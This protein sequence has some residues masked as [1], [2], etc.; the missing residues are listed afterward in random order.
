MQT[1]SMT[2][3]EKWIAVAQKLMAKPSEA[4]LCPFCLA[5]DL[6]V[7]DVPFGISDGPERWISCPFCKE[8]T[9]LRYRRKIKRRVAD[10]LAKFR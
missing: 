8:T 5:S 4:V 2:K 3:A 10:A 9:A 1:S 6:E 7:T